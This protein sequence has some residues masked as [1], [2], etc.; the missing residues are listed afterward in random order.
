MVASVGLPTPRFLVVEQAEALEGLHELVDATGHPISFPVFVKP[1]CEGSSM[2]IRRASRIED[3]KVLRE[4]AA[5]LLMDYQQPVLVE[6]F[7]SGP[8]FT[9]GILGNGERI[10]TL[11]IMEV[12]PRKGPIDS[13]V[14][15]L[16]VKR[17][18]LEEVEYQVPPKRPASVIAELERVA[19]GCYRAL[20][21]RDVSRVDLRMDR[22][23]QPKFLEVNPLPGLH[24]VNGDIVIMS[25]RVGRSYQ[26]LIGGIVEEARLRL[27]I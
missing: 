11:A 27:G 12:A 5:L 9:I 25:K 3:L 6:E 18:Y 14:Y 19:L 26:E 1:L 13:F 2:G 8:E 22:E 21:C 7:C 20:G 4:R 15:S 23:G 17:N 24:P 16:E 10:R